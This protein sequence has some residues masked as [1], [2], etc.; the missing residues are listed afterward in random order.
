MRGLKG[1][2]TRS[3]RAVIALRDACD[4]TALT[5]LERQSSS[6]ENSRADDAEIDVC[7]APGMEL[8]PYQR[9]G[10]R[11]ALSMDR[12]LIADDPGLGK[13]PQAIAATI[14]TPW[15]KRVLVICPAS[16]ATNWCDEIKRWSPDKHRV[17][18]ACGKVNEKKL[19]KE[20][21]FV[22]ADGEERLWIVT[23]FEG[24]RSV[25]G[26]RPGYVGRKI[27]SLTPFDMV[28][29][30]EVH[31]IGSPSSLQTKS[32]VAQ[33]MRAKKSIFLT[34]TPLP[35]NILDMQPILGCID[36]IV[37]EAR[38][39][40]LRYCAWESNNFGSVPKGLREDRAAELQDLLRANGM[41]RRTKA[42]V[43]KELP[44][45]VYRTQVFAPNKKQ[46][47]LLPK[48]K[49][50]EMALANDEVARAMAEREQAERSGDARAMLAAIAKEID[51]T[52]ASFETIS[53]DRVASGISMV[54]DALAYIVSRAQGKRKAIVFAWHREVTESLYAG[55]GGASSAVL[56]LGGQDPK[57]RAQYVQ[58]FQTD[59]S[60]QFAVTSIGSSAEGITLTASSLV[61]FVEFPWTSVKLTQ[62]EDLAHRLTQKETIEIDY[63]V[64]E[65]SPDAYMA[66]LIAKKAKYA[67][68]ALD[69]KTD[70][71]TPLDLGFQVT[72]QAFVPHSGQGWTPSS[73]RSR[74]STQAPSVVVQS[75][76]EALRSTKIDH[77]YDAAVKEAL[78]DI[79]P[80]QW[81]VDLLDL[82]SRL[83]KGSA[84]MVRL[85]KEHK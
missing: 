43:L 80:N 77:W 83:T 31:R 85:Q 41:L 48:P 4:E 16:V 68:L 5:E 50:I 39:F 20:N 58:R 57:L 1:W 19:E 38:S 25:I 66:S 28:I 74:L 33:V 10:V 27:A 18:L 84:E 75:Q 52:G 6:I 63:L 79:P 42:D 44:P 60:V 29:V 62:A 15:A 59:P 71:A 72:P 45:K 32:C 46:R 67:A 14:G 78:L 13:T 49:Q 73:K 3:L 23:S 36:P 12:C 34:G 65:G 55:L 30:D 21:A 24:V 76:I 35:N 53:R 54:K 8:R 37:F 61:I 47:S 22:S 26:K 11:W 56:L 7:L 82:S 64:V 81:T 70:F 69:E 2:W 40:A 9:A 17:V 51:A